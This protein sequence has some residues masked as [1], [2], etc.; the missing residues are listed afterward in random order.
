MS[1]YLPTKQQELSLILG[2]SMTN[3][4]YT[5][6]LALNHLCVSYYSDN[7]HVLLKDKTLE[8]FLSK[9][10][11]VQS[12]KMKFRGIEW[13]CVLQSNPNLMNVEGWI[14]MI[15][16]PENIESITFSM[17]IFCTHRKDTCENTQTWYRARINYEILEK[18]RSLHS[19]FSLPRDVTELE[20]VYNFDILNIK[21]ND[22]TKYIQEG[23]NMDHSTDLSL[24]LTD[25]DWRALDSFKKDSMRSI[26]F[27]SD[28]QRCW[29]AG[30]RYDIEPDGWR[31][32]FLLDV[33][34]HRWSQKIAKMKVFYRVLVFGEYH[35]YETLTDCGWMEFDFAS[36]YYTKSDRICTMKASKKG[37]LPTDIS[38]ELLIVAIWDNDKKPIFDKSK[39]VDYGVIV[40]E[41]SD[42]EDI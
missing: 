27:P 2:Y 22:G 34:V 12:N 41:G 4:I 5:I 20:Y 38:I 33:T 37:V 29:T 36:K 15:A 17:K 7:H 16:V 23:I 42:H 25:A 11:M 26:P 6:P 14:N 39:W 21:Y 40:D 31:P 10:T 13:I 1:D 8:Q 30:L 35:Q 32:A 24:K 28:K 3:S 19:V 18:S 9:S